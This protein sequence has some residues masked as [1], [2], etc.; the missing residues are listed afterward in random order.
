MKTKIN[1][2]K[3]SSSSVAIG[4][5]AVVIIVALVYFGLNLKNQSA[6]APSITSTGVMTN[7]AG[8][9]YGVTTDKTAYTPNEQ[10]AITVTIYNNSTAPQVFSFKNGCQ[11]SYEVAGFDLAKHVECLPD[12][13]SFAL[14]PKTSEKVKIIHYP[15]L[16]KLPVGTHVLTGSIIG[17][18]MATT[19]IIIK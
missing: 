7:I 2:Q 6:V 12:P 5:I 3:G 13:S 14:A 17:Y 11:V 18:G 16:E 4:V 1:F 19:S 10:I 8:V 9:S 15:A